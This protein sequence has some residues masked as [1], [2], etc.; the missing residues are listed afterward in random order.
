MSAS[1]PGGPAAAPAP[2]G[3]GAALVPID[4][5]AELGAA[6]L[7]RLAVRLMRPVEA[8][9]ALLLTLITVLLLVGVAARYV[10]TLPM[11]WI[12]EVVSLSFL[13]LAMVGAVI[14]MH[15][16]E[17]LRLTLV[18]ERVPERWRGYVQAF[19]L[20]AVAAMLLVLAGPALEYA[21]DEWAIRTP[22][23]GLPNALRVSAIA[24]GLLAMLALLVAFALRTVRGVELAAAVALLTAIGLA[25]WLGKPWLLMLGNVNLLLFLGGVVS[26]CLVAGVPIGFCFGLATLAY[27]GFATTVPLTVVVGRMDEGM[28]SIILVSVPIFVLLG[29]VL[30]S[31]G[32]GKAIV[33]VLAALLGHIKAGMSYALL[34]SLFIVSGISG[35][36]VSDMATVA[37]ALFPEMKRRGHKPPEM[38]A[39]LATGAAMAD[40]VPPSIVLIVL[41]SVAGVS[42]AGLFQSGFVIAMVLLLALLLL[43]RWKARHEVMEGVRRAPWAAVGRLVLVASPALVLPFLIRS[44]V[45][46]GVAT[47]TEVSTIAV[48]YALI[49]GKLLYGRGEGGL[50]GRKVYAM[51]VEAAGL[52]GAILIILGT[53]SGMA[54]AIAQSGFVNQLSSFMTTLPGGPLAFLAVTILVFVVLGCVLEGLPA[55]LLL[56]PIM[57]PI[58]KKL[59]VHDIHYSMV[60]V[61]AMNIGLML[62]PIGVGFYVA[63]RI[64]GDSPDAVMKAIWPYIGALV[65]G[66]VVIAAVPWLS[67][68]AL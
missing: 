63:C 64:G 32:M 9:G 1:G 31:T 46:G 61:T 50:T 41:G 47:A 2:A 43:A 20:A 18:V 8:L 15:R 5:A 45:G 40:T 49:I 53:A 33:D 25:C 60:V 13:W 29:C 52:S 14:A 4:P 17:H 24:F 44:A 67:T 11:V 57:F 37:P 35:S 34:G 3:A 7:P 22:E 23:L 48:A 6:T 39:L 56:A 38:I 58:A 21:R 66:L 68:V 36:K 42:I 16:N 28:S 12:D 54:W 62:P 55:I 30:D 26:L 59:G 19:A 65:V 51:L 10:F 27:L